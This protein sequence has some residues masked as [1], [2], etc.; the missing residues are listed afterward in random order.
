L[1]VKQGAKIL[2]ATAI[3][4][5]ISG[6]SS[7]RSL[8]TYHKIFRV[9]D[10]SSIAHASVHRAFD[11]DFVPPGNRETAGLLREKMSGLFPA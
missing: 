3:L 11:Y 7:L 6:C 5:S 9:A 4:I 8:E 10:K 1:A 2:S